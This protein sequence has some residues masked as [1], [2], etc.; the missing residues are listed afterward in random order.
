[1]STELQNQ[2]LTFISTIDPSENPYIALSRYVKDQ[3]LPTVPEA[4]IIQLYVLGIL[5]G[6][7][8]LL[9]L[10]SIAIRIKKRIF[11]L[12]TI[13]HSPEYLIKPHFSLPWSIIAAIMLV[14]FEFFIAQCASLFRKDLKSELGYWIFLC[15]ASA[16]VGGAFAAHALATNFLITSSPRNQRRWSIANN[17]GGILAPIIYLSVILPLGILG[18]KRFSNVAATYSQFDD[19]LGGLSREWVTGTRISIIKLTP[20]LPLIDKVLHQ[21]SLLWKSWRQVF[22]FYAVSAFILVIVLVTIALG[23]LSS[24]RQTIKESQTVL[25]A[26]RAGASARQQV[27]RTW[28]TLVMT[29]VAFVLLGSIFVGIGIFAALNPSSL[30]RGTESQCVVL[31]PLYGF[32]ILGFPTAALLVW[33]AIESTPNSTGSSQTKSS[34]FS[35]SKKGSRE[36]DSEIN[37]YSIELNGR[38]TRTNQ[39][40]PDLAVRFDRSAVNVS[41]EVEIKGEE[42]FE[43]DEK[44]FPPSTT[45]YR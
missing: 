44:A 24:L 15:W 26:D 41:V 13:T 2:L 37:K 39:E 35:N 36:L 25:S 33:R 7:T 38:R 8:L 27:H 14:L 4:A 11:F 3:F 10:V 23:F 31:I 6:A 5:L 22:T 45:V 42:E 43:D 9:V 32:A 18:G 40:R 17:L 30:T 20:A 29:V 12:Y 16:W 28:Q 21:E 1:M 34:R 19:I